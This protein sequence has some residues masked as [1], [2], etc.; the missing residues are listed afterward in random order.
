MINYNI[1]T[2]I[3]ATMYFKVIKVV[4]FMLNAYHNK[5]I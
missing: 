3:N 5:K 4:Y 1:T 2:V